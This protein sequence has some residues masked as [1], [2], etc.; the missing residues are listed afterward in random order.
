MSTCTRVIQID[1]VYALYMY[2]HFHAC[3]YMHRSVSPTT[4]EGVTPSKGLLRVPQREGRSTPSAGVAPPGW[5][6]AGVLKMH[7]LGG[8]SFS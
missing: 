1:E 5:K 8:L 3:I 6:D 2:T 4:Y 7:A